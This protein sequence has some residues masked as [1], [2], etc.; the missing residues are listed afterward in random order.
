M[1]ID[2]FSAF[3]RELTKIAVEKRADWRRA[4]LGA[5]IGALGGAGLGAAVSNKENR[6]RNALIG[7]LAG[8]ALGAAGGKL[9]KG[10]PAPINAPPS[11]PV[12]PILPEGHG[13]LA[14]TSQVLS[15]DFK[16]PIHPPVDHLDPA[17]FSQHAHEVAD[18][19]TRFSRNNSHILLSSQGD[20]SLQHARLGSLE[21]T[22]KSHARFSDL[23]DRLGAPPDPLTPGSYRSMVLTEPTPG[24]PHYQLA[25]DMLK[26]NG[27]LPPVAVN[28]SNEQHLSEMVLHL[29]ENASHAARHGV[30]RDL[31]PLVQQASEH[32]DAGRLADA[33]PILE[34]LQRRVSAFRQ[35]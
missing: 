2:T 19:T 7:G 27:V 11:P 15:Q 17:Q 6:G 26:R 13:H 20:R 12:R 29:S 16:V 31:K 21:D 25:Q 34:E 22:R 1:D 32:L 5:G 10:R 35:P 18:A 3:S 24:H 14:R 30:H 8:G 4:A 33:R 28:P 9:W 23:V